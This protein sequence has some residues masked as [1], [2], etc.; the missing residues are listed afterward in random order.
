MF[1]HDEDVRVVEFIKLLLDDGS[2]PCSGCPHRRHCAEHEIA[3]TDYHL[4]VNSANHQR[5]RDRKP[6]RH[7][8][9]RIYSART[10]ILS[11]LKDTPPKDMPW[12]Y[13]TV[14]RA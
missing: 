10:D 13:S 14:R 1:L 4:Y 11:Q 12:E 7:R 3:C 8:Y 6:T 5:Q 9:Q 2:C